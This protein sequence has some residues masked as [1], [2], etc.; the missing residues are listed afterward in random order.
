MLPFS[1]FE[2]RSY[3]PSHL[4]QGSLLLHG[5][6]LLLF[7][8]SP[9]LWALF[10]LILGANHLLLTALGLWPKSHWLG[11][12]LV[13]VRQS[14]K[15]EVFLTFDD[16]PDPEV[17]PWVLDLLDRHDM[18]ATFFLVGDRVLQYPEIAREIAIRGHGIGNHSMH[19][20]TGFAFQSIRGFKAELEAAQKAIEWVTGVRPVYFRAPFGFRSPLLEPALCEI[21]LWLVAWTR[22]GFDTRCR[23]AGRVLQ[24]LVNSLGP[25]DIL[26]LHDG[27]S[28]PRTI[29]PPIVLEVLPKLLQVLEDRH[30]QSR[31]L[32][33]KHRGVFQSKTSEAGE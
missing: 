16:G 13:R 6:I 30:M 7:L 17:T 9:E 11:P 14:A 1:A 20:R 26:L 21:G 4:I 24:R 28:G 29:H 23:N 3:H 8:L 10:A 12:N 15:H 31:A 32:D 27:R 19:H 5:F 25:G 22:R 33:L 2:H 18:K